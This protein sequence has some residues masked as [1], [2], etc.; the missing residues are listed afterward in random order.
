MKR[1]VH[2]AKNYGEAR[3]WDVL[4]QVMMSPEDRQQIA[5]E[6]RRRFYG[7]RNPNIRRKKK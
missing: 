5:K 6:L 4:Q 3:K 2:K 1:A 7:N